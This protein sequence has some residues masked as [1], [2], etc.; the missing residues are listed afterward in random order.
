MWSRVLSH[1]APRATRLR[2]VPGL[3]EREDDVEFEE[4]S[5]A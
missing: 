3:A 1:L 4:F 5:A 2:V